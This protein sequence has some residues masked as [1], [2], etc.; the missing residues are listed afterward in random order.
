MGPTGN[1]H[2]EVFCG[3]MLVSSPLSNPP[4]SK[5]GFRSPQSRRDWE[6]GKPDRLASVRLHKYV[7]SSPL[8]K[9]FCSKG[10]AN[11]HERVYCIFDAGELS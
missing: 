11:M 7:L 3:V 6:T 5:L 2:V 9:F 8:S 10:P 1:S 4:A